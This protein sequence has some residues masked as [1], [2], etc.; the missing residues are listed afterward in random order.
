MTAEQE[1]LGKIIS[2]LDTMNFE[3]ASTYDR[4]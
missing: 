3:V 4:K 2:P 1:F